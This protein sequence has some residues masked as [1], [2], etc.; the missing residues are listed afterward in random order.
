MVYFTT[1]VVFLYNSF[2][3]YLIK[4]LKNNSNHIKKIINLMW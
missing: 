3:Y 2:P 4:I 1:F